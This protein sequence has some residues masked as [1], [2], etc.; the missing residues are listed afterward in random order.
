MLKL[1]LLTLT[2]ITMACH[3]RPDFPN[4][5]V[6][7]GHALAV[8]QDSLLIRL[9][10]GDDILRTVADTM[11]TNKWVRIS[12]LIGPSNLTIRHYCIQ[13]MIRG[14]PYNFNKI[15]R[16]VQTLSYQDT[17]YGGLW[18]EGYSYWEY[19][20]RALKLYQEKFSGYKFEELQSA[21]NT[22]NESFVRT[23][24]KR[25]SLWYPAPYG[26]LRNEPLYPELQ[27]LAKN[28]RPETNITLSIISKRK[29]GYI[30]T[31]TIYPYPLGLNNH[32]PIDT[33]RVHVI[34]GEPQ[35]NWYTGYQDKYNSK[36]EE[37]ND[38]FNVKRLNSLRKLR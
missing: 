14:V 36:K 30:E 4:Y 37:W 10:R 31:Y 20:N 17:K 35:F 27:K 7:N 38:T 19:T 23:A 2:I 15:T 5:N 26:D 29:S 25:D 28:L 6:Q 3:Q 11:A 32:I 18:S 34:E 16:L 1:L 9:E 12:Q 22:I 21:M 24:Y 13:D 33:L 8:K